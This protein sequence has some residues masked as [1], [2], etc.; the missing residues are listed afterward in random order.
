MVD[1]CDVCDGDGTS[2]LPNEVTLGTT[3]T[4]TLEVMYSSS[5]AIAGFQFSVAGATATSASGGAAEAAGFSVTVLGSVAVL[6]YS[7]SGATIPAGTGLLTTVTIDYSTAGD[8]CLTDVFMSDSSATE[9]TFTTGECISLV[10]DD[11]DADTI[12]D[13]ADEYP[14][15]FENFYDDCDVCGGDGTSCLPISL[16]LGDVTTSSVDVMYSSSSAIGGFQFA[17]S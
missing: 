13:H 14:N 2:C 4:S 6:G 11:T 10:C 16:T 8:L 1:S 9:L 5:T 15:C 3:T 7:A 17:I 12:C